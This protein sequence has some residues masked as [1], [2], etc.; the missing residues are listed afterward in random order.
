MPDEPTSIEVSP[1]LLPAAPLTTFPPASDRK[2]ERANSAPP[3]EV[4]EGDRVAGPQ[5]P[6]I[7]P[8]SAR[9]EPSIHHGW[10]S[11]KCAANWVTAKSNG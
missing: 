9:P 2:P 6:G 5:L 11:L 8:I 7:R 4:G 10:H 1:R 3:G